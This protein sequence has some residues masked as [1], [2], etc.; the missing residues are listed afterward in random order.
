LRPTLAIRPCLKTTFL[1][2][3]KEANMQ[4]KTIVLHL[5]QQRPQLHDQLRKNRMLLPTLD[6]YASDLKASH[7]AWKDRLSQAKPG[8][9]E[10]QI[11]AEAL[12]LALQAMEDCLPSESPPDDSETLSLEE[13]MTFLRRHTPPA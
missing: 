5:L 13:A 7:E 1:S 8:S 6:L 2:S 9:S 3:P 11:A 10:S 4:Y 12:E